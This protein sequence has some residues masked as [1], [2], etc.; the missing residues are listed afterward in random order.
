[1][2]SGITILPIT[3]S[4]IVFL[5]TAAM[6][7]PLAA[8]TADAAA[9]A[10]AIAKEAYLTIDRHPF[11]GEILVAAAKR[12]DEAHALNQ[13]EPYV[14][15]GAAQL[16]LAGGYRSGSWRDASNYAPGAIDRASA[17]VQRA[18][19]ADSKLADA[20]LDA[21]Y[22]ALILRRLDDAKREIDLA[23]N[24][25]P[26]AFRPV[27]YLAVWHW[28]QGSI[29]Q[30]QDTLRIARTLA[31]DAR[32]Q[33]LILTQL[34]VMAIARGDDEQREKILKAFIA[35]DPNDR[36]KH[37]NYGWFLL[38]KERYDEAIAEF[39]KAIALGGYPNAQRGLD[40]ARHARQ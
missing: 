11:E 17:L 19:Q 16:V 2:S 26:S 9:R 15:L 5:A 4:L 34:E 12:L 32:D 35:L 27:Y 25:D 24:L 38:E 6:A 13:K 10:R 7:T 3:R 14:Y 28:Q 22:L 21:A 36:W 8:V 20:H 29:M 40:Q 39:D 23:H 18:I 31:R 30:C 37:G 1:M 33:A